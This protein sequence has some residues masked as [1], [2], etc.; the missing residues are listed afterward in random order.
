MYYPEEVV[1]EVRSRN[2][3]VDVIGQYVHL[4]KK[5]A[6][7]FGLCPFH[8]EK[9]PSFS[10]SASKQMYYCFGC[11]AGGNVVSFLMNYENMSFQEA[12][13]VLADRAGIELPE[14]SMSEEA[15]KKAG[16]R[17]RLLALN[18]DA[19]AFY[20]K[21]LRSPDGQ[22]GMDYF[23]KRK[24]QKET[25]HSFGLG[26][27]GKNSAVCRYLK[28]KG[29]SDQ[30]IIKAGLARVD[31]KRGM[32][33]RF[34][35]RVMFPIMDVNNRVI[36]FG[37]RVMGDGEPKYLNSPET[38]VF[39]KGRN[40]YG[41]NVAKKSRKGYMIACEGYMDVIS[42][43]QAGFT[44]A[45]ASLGTA[46]TENHARVLK[47][48]TDDVRLTYDSD[49][50]GVKA[51]MRAIPILKKVGISTSIIHLEPYKDPDEFI[52]N[53]GPQEFQKRIDNAEDSLLFELHVMR[54]NYDIGK[55][56]GRTK[57]EQAMARRLALIEDELERANYTEA[58]ATEYSIPS[59]VLKR[60]VEQARVMSVSADGHPV[61]DSAVNTVKTQERRPDQKKKTEDGLT[62]A[63]KLLLTYI[64]DDPAVYKAVKPYVS[65]EDFSEGLS[66]M[67]AENLFKQLEADD[68]RPAAIIS[69]FDEPEQ[70]KAVAEI[71]NT[72]LDEGLSV[73]EREKA[74]TDLVIRIKRTSLGR[75]NSGADLIE[76]MVQ[77]KKIMEKLQ[78]IRISL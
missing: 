57:F 25:L 34:W 38:P 72:K 7:Y 2:D 27:A 48:Y 22:I 40:L 39:D 13:K 12:I 58:V 30:E 61:A 65:A 23:R 50:A 68:F 59:D 29:Y 54:R 41:L 36:G 77:E 44:E 76:R 42:M 33:D 17:A 28:E 16:E 56:D 9:S 14:E 62:K 15:K 8:N 1:E 19:A 5:G 75:M 47:K 45:V 73:A 21:M 4:T 18:K 24:L 71:F 3:I 31:E 43:H 49:N 51:A 64:T 26:Y 37:G 52:K 78:T 6:N 35:N 66:R 69:M 74:L 20:Y 55:P 70:Q 63:E 32:T 11:G 67:A 46:F 60:A 10:V 53:L